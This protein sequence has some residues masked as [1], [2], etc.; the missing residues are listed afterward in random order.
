MTQLVSLDLSGN[1]LRFV[2]ELDELVNLKTL[3]L[4]DNRI[5][6]IDSWIQNL[7]SLEHLDMQNNKLILVK[8]LLELPLLEIVL[9]QGNMIRDIEFLKRH[10]KYNQTWIRPFKLWT[11]CSVPFIRLSTK[12][13]TQI[14]LDFFFGGIRSTLV[15]LMIILNIVVTSRQ[16]RGFIC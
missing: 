3:I 6:R 14:T 7:Q 10:R 15:Y 1:E 2:L 16:G 13:K 4:K 8:L 9:L 11:R 5:A 12:T